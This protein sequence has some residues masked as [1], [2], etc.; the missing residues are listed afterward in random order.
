MAMSTRAKY[1]AELVRET[2]NVPEFE[3]S[4][5]FTSQKYKGIF[6]AWMKGT[7]PAHLFIYYQK[8]YK[9]TD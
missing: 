7:G 9:V 6:D 2:F 1:M 8:P 3:A 5:P 4:E